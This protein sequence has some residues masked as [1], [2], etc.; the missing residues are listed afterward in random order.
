[1]KLLRSA[2]GKTRGGRNRNKNLRKECGIKDTL[3]I[4]E[5]K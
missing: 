3:T 2:E 5:M 1:M 4:L